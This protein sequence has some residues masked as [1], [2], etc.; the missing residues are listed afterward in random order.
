MIVAAH[1]K[2]DE[3]RQ[4]MSINV[5]YRAVMHITNRCQYTKISIHNLYKLK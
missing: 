4:L 3:R 5:S 2:D 1:V